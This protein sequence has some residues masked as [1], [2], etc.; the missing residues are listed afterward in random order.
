LDNHTCRVIGC[1]VGSFVSEDALQDHIEEHHLQ[2]INGRY[3]C[4][5]EGCVKKHTKKSAAHICHE[6]H[7]RSCGKT[8]CAPTEPFSD[9]HLH[10]LK[11]HYYVHSGK[12]AFTCDFPGC[13]SSHA[14][15]A[16]LKVHQ[17]RHNPKQFGCEECD[18][19][20]T[21]QNQLRT[22]VNAVH[23]REKH[24]K[25]PD[26]GYA[27]DD[28]SN[29]SSHRRKQHTFGIPCP[30]SNYTLHRP[31]SHIHHLISSELVLCAYK[32]GRQ[33]EMEKHMKASHH[34]V[35]MFDNEGSFEMYWK[36]EKKKVEETRQQSERE[37]EKEKE[38]EI[39][40]SA[41]TAPLQ[42]PIITTNDVMGYIDPSH[43]LNTHAGVSNVLGIW[44][45][46]DKRQDQNDGM[47]LDMN[48]GLD[49]GIVDA[50]T[51][52]NNGLSFN[53]PFTTS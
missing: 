39:E 51:L 44:N 15:R 43:V 10:K 46:I 26:C 34:S 28:S 31:P 7:A 4:Q 33:A 53:Y 22:H 11:R 29:M 3:I 40:S 27:C 50:N 42:F 52:F 36:G 23:K 6:A 19:V 35:W 49:M 20:F 37:K 21:T 1:N 17:A 13:G 24:F 38:K 47:V 16:Q 2:K 9:T 32:D 25:C 5:W 8:Y 14:T 12:K 41:L 45:G 48:V 30:C 18:R